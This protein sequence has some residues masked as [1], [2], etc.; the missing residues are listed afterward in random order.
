MTFIYFATTDVISFF[1]DS[2]S[3]SSIYS[4]SKTIDKHNSN[5]N[6]DNK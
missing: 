3:M 2:D 4:Q 5:N 1:S 6:N